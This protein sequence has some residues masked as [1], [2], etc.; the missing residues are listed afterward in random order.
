[1]TH[2]FRGALFDGFGQIDRRICGRPDAPVFPVESSTSREAEAFAMPTNHGRRLHNDGTV[3]NHSRPPTTTPTGTDQRPYDSVA[4]P[5]KNAE[6][7]TKGKNLKL[8]R[9]SI[10]KGSQESCR[11]RNQA[12]RTWNREKKGNS[13]FSATP[14]FARATRGA[15]PTFSLTRVLRCAHV[16][17]LPLLPAAIARPITHPI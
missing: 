2:K 16:D 9:R 3:A 1:M 10:A 17:A 14:R 8:K 13:N 11:R 6:L 4:S 15:A 5:L 7:M 12:M